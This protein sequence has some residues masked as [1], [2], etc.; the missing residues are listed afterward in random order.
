MN[1]EDTHTS[2]PEGS[3][4]VEATATVVAIEDDL[5][6]LETRRTNACSTCGA[7]GAC[8]TSAL[9]EVLGRKPNMLKIPNNFDAVPGEQ[10]I[11]GLPEGALVLASM[12]AYMIPLVAMIGLALV[13]LGLGFSESLAAL[14]AIIGFAGGMWTAGRLTKKAGKRFEPR[15]LRRTPFA[16]RSEACGR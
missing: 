1:F 15:F 13:V 11:I 6:V 5:A 9:G 12:A 3:D 7:A 10:V 16:L 2:S 14:A 8:G 4:F